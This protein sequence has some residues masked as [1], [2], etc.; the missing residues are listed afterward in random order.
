MGDKKEKKERKPSG[1][2]GPGAHDLLQP[3]DH[4][5]ICNDPIM[6]TGTLVGN[7]R[8]GKSRLNRQT[9]TTTTAP[10]GHIKVEYELSVGKNRTHLDAEEISDHESKVYLDPDKIGGDK[11]D[12][13]GR[14]LGSAD[15]EFVITK[16]EEEDGM[17]VVWTEDWEYLDR[18]VRE[19]LG[20]PTGGEESE[21]KQ[22]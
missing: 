13:V 12:L 16:A 2:F 11:D 9:F 7:H 1:P 5:P 3:A 15:D 10:S 4:R 21:D 18:Q 20:F 17:I 22:G 8:Q 6:T 19:N 14:T